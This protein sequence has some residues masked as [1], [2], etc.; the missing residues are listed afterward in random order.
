MTTTP[1]S[2]GGLVLWLDAIMQQMRRTQSTLD[3]HTADQAAHLRG[4]LHAIQDAAD[5]A[6]REQGQ[7]RYDDA[8]ASLSRAAALLRDEVYPHLAAWHEA[9]TDPVSAQQLQSMME[10]LSCLF[11]DEEL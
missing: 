8:L 7:C 2:I 1:T 4:S 6:V 3:R 11:A 5:Q 10:T 9:E